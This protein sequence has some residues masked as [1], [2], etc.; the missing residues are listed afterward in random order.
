MKGSNRVAMIG[1][2]IVFSDKQMSEF[3]LRYDYDWKKWLDFSSWF[4]N[5]Q[6]SSWCHID[7][8]FISGQKKTEPKPKKM[9]SPKFH[10]NV[11]INWN[12]FGRKSERITQLLD[13][14]CL[15]YWNVCMWRSNVRVILF[16]LPEVALL[17]FYYVR[18]KA[19]NTM[20]CCG[21]STVHFEFP[22]FGIKTKS[23]NG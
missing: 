14:F 21:H 16:L 1:G 10:R 9:K 5:V 19:D 11:T 15:V 22:P 20:C 2:W 18:T 17:K 6:L 4:W 12:S 7:L 13:C 23:R 3:P 8:I